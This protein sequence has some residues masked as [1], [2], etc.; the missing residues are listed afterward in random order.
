MRRINKYILPTLQSG[1]IVESSQSLSQEGK[2][3]RGN[4][5]YPVYPFFE[6]RKSEII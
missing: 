3:N 5:I 1:V 6:Q 4:E 2:Y